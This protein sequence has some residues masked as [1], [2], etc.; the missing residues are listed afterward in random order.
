M[1][2]FSDVHEG[3][4]IARLTADRLLGTSNEQKGRSGADLRR[5][6]GDMKTNA[7]NFIVDNVIAQKLSDCFT[8]ARL[9]G[10]TG[11]EFTR[12]Y[13]ELADIAAVSLLAKL[14]RDACVSFALQEASTVLVDVKFTSRNDVERVRVEINTSF[15]QAEE[16]A[17]DDMALVS[18]RALVSLHAAVIF[19]L[20]ETARP[21]PQMLNFEFASARPTLVLSQ[22]LYDTAAK[23]DELRKENKVV[24]PAFGPRSGRALAF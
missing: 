15:N 13:R 22:R 11:D 16:V 8:Q 6:C 17:A 2:P 20:S 24:H 1:I 3:A 14:I 12:I 18:Y 4:A 10:A 23:A 7:D 21:L 5:A 9:T 19:Y